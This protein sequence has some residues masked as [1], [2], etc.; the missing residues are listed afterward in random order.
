MFKV[1]FRSWAIWL[2]SVNAIIRNYKSDFSF[3]MKLNEKASL[4]SLETERGSAK[5]TVH[6]WSV[7]FFEFFA[8]LTEGMLVQTSFSSRAS[9]TIW[10]CS[11]ILYRISS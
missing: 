6:R 1:G 7:V 2:L 8:G 11:Y 4:L 5:C 10:F 3:L 9:S